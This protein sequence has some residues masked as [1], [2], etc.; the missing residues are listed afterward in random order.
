MVFCKEKLIRSVHPLSQR[1]A[2]YPQLCQ[3]TKPAEVLI[4]FMHLHSLLI[5]TH[6]LYGDANEAAKRSIP[7]SFLQKLLHGKDKEIYCQLAVQFD[8]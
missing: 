5:H 2:I 8:S 4:L 7:L 6:T 1:E 3:L